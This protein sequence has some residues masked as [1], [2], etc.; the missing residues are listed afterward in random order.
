MPGPY[1]SKS[2]LSVSQFEITLKD[3]PSFRAGSLLLSVLI[4][5]RPHPFKWPRTHSRLPR[6]CKSCQGRNGLCGSLKFPWCPG[7][8]WTHDVQDSIGGKKE[9]GSSVLLSAH[10]QKLFR[11]LTG[12]QNARDCVQNSEGLRLQG[13]NRTLF[14]WFV[15][16][17][18]CVRV[19]EG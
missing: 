14:L 8:C 12:V 9:Y 10:Y 15:F 16:I 19:G 13:L 7:Q 6:G 17:M 1:S 11:Q 3:I 5:L 4:H 2:L 18:L